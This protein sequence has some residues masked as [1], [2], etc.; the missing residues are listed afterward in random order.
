MRIVEVF[1]LLHNT[2]L[3]VGNIPI[4]YLCALPVLRG[5]KYTYKEKNTFLL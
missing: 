2:G 1:D 4:R 5:S 3:Q